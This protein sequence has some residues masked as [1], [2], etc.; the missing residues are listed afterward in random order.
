M[1]VMR[2]D[3]PLGKFKQVSLA[4]LQPY[5]IALTE[6]DTTLRQLFDIAC[7]RQQLLF[8]PVLTSNYV[9]TLHNFVV[10]S[11]GISISGE[12]SVRYRVAK[13][14]M[15]IVPIR[16]RS[17]DGRSMEVQTLVGRILPKVVQTFLDYFLVRLT[18]ANPP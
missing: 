2:H 4:Q 14:E 12:V 11:G 5:P 7:S 17:L 13:G 10:Y 8:E 9:E 1:A 18:E 3:H 15:I 6:P 16:D